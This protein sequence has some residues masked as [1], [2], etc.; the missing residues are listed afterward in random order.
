MESFCGFQDGLLL[1]FKLVMSLIGL[2]QIFCKD[3]AKLCSL[4]A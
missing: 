2:Q 4:P 3:T 1:S